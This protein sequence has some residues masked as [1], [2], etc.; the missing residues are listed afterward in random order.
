MLMVA[1]EATFDVD[2]QAKFTGVNGTSGLGYSIFAVP[3]LCLRY[4]FLADLP[5][6]T[7]NK[8]I[9][10][11][12]LKGPKNESLTATNQITVHGLLEGGEFCRR[13]YCADLDAEIPA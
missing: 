5:C 10:L 1:I 13:G 7:F 6:L 3:K 2:A 12:I 11:H 8:I 4:A 9:K